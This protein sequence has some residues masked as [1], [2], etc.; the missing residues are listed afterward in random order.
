MRVEKG[1]TTTRY[2][3]L[4]GI[5]RDRLQSALVGEDTKGSKG[6]TSSKKA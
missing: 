5:Q 3:G 1:A 6:S 4:P 2:A